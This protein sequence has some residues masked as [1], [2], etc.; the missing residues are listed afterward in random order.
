M[1]R[2]NIVDNGQVSLQMAVEAGE[3]DPKYLSRFKEWAEMTDNIRWQTIR[4][5]I[6]N[7]RYLLRLNYAE[8]FNQLDFSKKP[9]LTKALNNI[10]KR[11]EKLQKDEEELQYK[12]SAI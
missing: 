12:Y 2:S 7:R 10:Q 11:I 3:Y 1:T 5:A 9:E 4:K 8:V 6:Q